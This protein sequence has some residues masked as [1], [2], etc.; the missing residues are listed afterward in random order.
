MPESVGF[1]GTA[2]LAAGTGVA[3]WYGTST[4]RAVILALTPDELEGDDA[5]PYPASWPVPP[6]DWTWVVCAPGKFALTP[7]FINDSY[8]DGGSFNTKTPGWQPVVIPDGLTDWTGWSHA[9]V[10]T[11]RSRPMI[12][13]QQ[14]HIG[15]IVAAVAA[16]ATAVAEIIAPGTTHISLPIVLA[17]LAAAITAGVNVYE[18]NEEE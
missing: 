6:K 1:Y 8:V 9:L 10:G 12:R 17:S 11:A 16:A 14:L 2:P 18:T 13:K 3:L 5:M 15:A 7:G 4:G